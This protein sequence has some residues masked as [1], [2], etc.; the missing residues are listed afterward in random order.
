M[1]TRPKTTPLLAFSDP[2]ERANG[3]DRDIPGN[4]L[5]SFI[6]VAMIAS[7]LY[8]APVDAADSRNNTCVGLRE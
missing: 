3:V 8:R 1:R 6:G 5:S 4:F 2:T 7:A